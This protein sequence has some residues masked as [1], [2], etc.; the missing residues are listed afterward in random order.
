MLLNTKVPH[1]GQ[2]VPGLQMIEDWE[3]VLERY[4]C[5]FAL[6]I[7]TQPTAFRQC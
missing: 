3:S 5:M 2:K 7:P 6:L 1:L 4:H